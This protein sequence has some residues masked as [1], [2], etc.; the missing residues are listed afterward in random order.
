[1]KLTITHKYLLRKL[2]SSV[3]P[4]EQSS[5]V[6]NKQQSPGSDPLRISG[7]ESN[8]WT[9]LKK[10]WHLEAL[11]LAVF[12][13]SLSVWP[14]LITEIKTYSFPSL[15]N[16]GWW[17]LILLT[18]FSI[19]DCTGRFFVNRRF[20]LT[21]SN[22]WI[23]VMGRFIIVP[24]IVGIVK[25]WWLQSDFWSLLSVLFLGFGNGYLGTLTIIFVS[26]S[27]HPDE[28]RLIGPYT[29]FFLNAGLVLGS[30]VGLIL[31]KL[32]LR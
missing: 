24:I 19:S 9:V 16:S 14:P 22:V 12:L 27:V 15:Q 21:P 11:I 18:F 8:R 23:P 2:E 30:M 13:A 31:E 4:T 29:S 10:V 5:L 32:V 1:M 7:L 3:E 17:S 20:G 6:R 28:Q 25:E 26:E